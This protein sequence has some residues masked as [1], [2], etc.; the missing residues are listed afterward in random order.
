M[1]RYRY[2]LSEC[3]PSDSVNRFRLVSSAYIGALAREPG[4]VYVRVWIPDNMKLYKKPNAVY[5]TTNDSRSIKELGYDLIMTQWTGKRKVVPKGVD[6]AAL[7][8]WQRR[9]YFSSAFGDRESIVKEAE[10]E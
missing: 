6:L 9:L 2:I 4:R 10:H 1:R 7:A 3:K 8:E 5:S